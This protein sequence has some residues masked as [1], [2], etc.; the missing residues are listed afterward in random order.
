MSAFLIKIHYI[1]SIGFLLVFISNVSNSSY[2]CT[3]T[4]QCTIDTPTGGNTAQ[5]IITC[6]SGT[7]DI[8]CDGYQACK[9]FDINC[10][11]S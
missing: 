7:C 10:T 5:M 11:V 9:E 4:P 1:F 2:S 8:T 3:P 6:D